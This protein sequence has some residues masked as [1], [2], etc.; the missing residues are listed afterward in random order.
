MVKKEEARGFDV[1]FV[2]GRGGKCA[3]SVQT[4]SKTQKS[5]LPLVQRVPRAFYSPD[6]FYRAASKGLGLG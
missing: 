6:T 2:F 5:D 3:K 1:F 4:E